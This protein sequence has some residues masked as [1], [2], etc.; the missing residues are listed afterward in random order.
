MGPGGYVAGG[1]ISRRSGHP[2]SQKPSHRAARHGGPARS[3]GAGLG[4]LLVFLFA[5]PLAPPVAAQDPALTPDSLAHEF[6]TAIR[7]QAWDAVA[8]R[9]HPERMER[10][11]RWVV[12]LLDVPGTAEARRRVLGDTSRAAYA[13]AG[14]RRLFS[15]L[16]EGLSEDFPG[17]VHALVARDVEILGTVREGAELAHVVYRN[18]DRLSGAVPE[19]R[20]TT[21]RRTPDGWRILES[22]ELDL[23]RVALQGLLRRTT[24]PAPPD[25]AR[26]GRPPSA[27]PSPA[28][29]LAY[30]LEP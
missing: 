22:D 23:I 13:D 1:P 19:I 30:P 12:I 6:Q 21:L 17:L 20:V 29:R 24:P 26:T 14:P 7:A 4:T 15:R 25:T 28:A 27:A 11:H 5:V 3:S 2:I 10:F 9:V 8:A 16:L 18:S